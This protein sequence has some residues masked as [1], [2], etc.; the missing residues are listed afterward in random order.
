MHHVLIV[1][2]NPDVRLLLQIALEIAGMTVLEASDGQTGVRMAIE[3]RPACVIVDF[4]LPDIDGC[5]VAARIRAADPEG[6]IRLIAVTGYDGDAHRDRARASGF[7]TYLVKPVE[8]EM[9]VRTIESTLA[10]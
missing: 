2:D 8:P 10:R 7:D 9:L 1:E 6:A 3:R 4:G 5:T